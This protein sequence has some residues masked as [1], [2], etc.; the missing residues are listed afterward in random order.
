MLYDIV[1]AEARPGFRL[2]ARF[3]D[4][5]QGEIDL[6]HLAG[7]GVF[8]RWTQDP[9]EFEQVKVDPECGT[10]VWPG[11]VDVAPDRIY[12]EIAGSRGRETSGTST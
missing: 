12:Q 2:W 10:V 8:A 7:Q 5:T 6:S 3:E 9:S 1:E 11:G 4:G